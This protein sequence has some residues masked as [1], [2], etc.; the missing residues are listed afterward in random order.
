MGRPAWGEGPEPCGLLHL[1]QQETNPSGGQS[2][3]RI[4]RSLPEI[5]P[6]PKG[7]GFRQLP[8]VKNWVRGISPTRYIFNASE[9]RREGMLDESPPDGP[10]K[11][12]PSSTLGRR[13]GHFRAAGLKA[14]LWGWALWAPL[15]T[16]ATLLTPG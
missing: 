12:P 6:L 13:N 14:G 7:V 10:A 3:P 11:A 1:R 16:P 5:I 8:G 9:L 15:R 2:F 4:L